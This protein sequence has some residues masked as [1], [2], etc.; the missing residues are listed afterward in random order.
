MYQ[1]HPA[2]ESRQVVAED[3]DTDP[4]IEPL[5]DPPSDPEPPVQATQTR[6]P[7]V[8]LVSISS[9]VA[10]LKAETLATHKA[11]NKLSDAILGNGK[12]GLKTRMDRIERSHGWISRIFWIVITGSL[13]SFI[14]WG[15]KKL[16]GG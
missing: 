6:D 9:D 5:P 3:S 15:V 7:V 2:A 13:L 14:G 12:P 4:A 11:I 8:D 1:R 16:L 10:V